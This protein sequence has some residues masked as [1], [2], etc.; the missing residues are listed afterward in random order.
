[1]HTHRLSFL[2]TMINASVLESVAASAAAVSRLTA[3]VADNRCR[4]VV[5]GSVD[6]SHC[7]HDV[8]TGR[9]DDPSASR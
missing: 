4:A 5:S 1:M 9:C 8:T 7:R 2:L 3:C 6:E